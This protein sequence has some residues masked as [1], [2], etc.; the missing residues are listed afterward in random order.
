MLHNAAPSQT[1]WLYYH[2]ITS[3]KRFILHLEMHPNKKQG[4][5]YFDDKQ[6]NC[7]LV[8]SLSAPTAKQD[9]LLNYKNCHCL[10]EED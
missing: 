7:L 6:T 1:G 2:T 3:M 4:G 8:R 9:F 10:R 5:V